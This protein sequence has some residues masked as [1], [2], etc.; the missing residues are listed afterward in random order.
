MGAAIRRPDGVR[1]V[2]A[3]ITVARTA[4]AEVLRCDASMALPKGHEMAVKVET[5]R[6]RDS[7]SWA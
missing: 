5:E 1:G 3:G 6:K 7:L 2:T 4:R